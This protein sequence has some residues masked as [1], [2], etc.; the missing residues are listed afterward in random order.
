MTIEQISSNTDQSEFCDGSD[1]CQCDECF[2]KILVEMKEGLFD[3]SYDEDI[4]AE[5]VEE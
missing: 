1:T 4:I 2:D 5:E 3:Y